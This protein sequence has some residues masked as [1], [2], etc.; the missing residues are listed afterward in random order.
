MDLDQEMQRALDGVPEDTGM[1][2]MMGFDAKGKG[3][4]TLQQRL[5]N[6]VDDSMDVD[7]DASPPPDGD[8]GHSTQTTE[9]HLKRKWCVSSVS[10]NLRLCIMDCVGRRALTIRASGHDLWKRSRQARLRCLRLR[11]KKTC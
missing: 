10:N 4:E 9:R 6:L 2:P 3:K 11:R 7:E 8:T 1:L 5:W